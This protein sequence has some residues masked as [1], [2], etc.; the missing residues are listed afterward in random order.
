MWREEGCHEE[1]AVGAIKNLSA[2]EW[3]L[4]PAEVEKKSR[5]KGKGGGRS[6]M[7]V[8]LEAFAEGFTFRDRHS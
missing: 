6:R 2:H 4:S 8:T 7:S 3:D 1:S 5:I